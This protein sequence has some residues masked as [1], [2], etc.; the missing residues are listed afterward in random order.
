MSE[1]SPPGG[2]QV[3]SPEQNCWADDREFFRLLVI[4]SLEDGLVRYSRRRDLLSAAQRLGLDR[5]E[6]NL[7]IAEVQYGQGHP[8]FPG[9]PAAVRLSGSALEAP[10]SWRQRL[11][12]PLLVIS[13]LELAAIFYLLS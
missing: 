1:S 5:F 2:P 8:S 9:P 4:S 3:Q 13:V 7:I 10:W 11:W 12:L 6:A